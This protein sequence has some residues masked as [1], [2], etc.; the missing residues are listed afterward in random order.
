MTLTIL[1]ELPYDKGKKKH[2]SAIYVLSEFSIGL[3]GRVSRPIFE[4]IPL[5]KFRPS[6]AQVTPIV[7]VHYIHLYRDPS[8]AKRNMIYI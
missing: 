3:I 5:A 2:P 6:T 7:Q 8:V 1:M 4:S